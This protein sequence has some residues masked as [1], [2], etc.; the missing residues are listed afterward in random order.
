MPILYWCNNEEDSNYDDKNDDDH[1][2]DDNEDDADDDNDCTPTELLT[3]GQTASLEENQG[4]HDDL[5]YGK[6]YLQSI[7]ENHSL[8]KSH[9]STAPGL[10]VRLA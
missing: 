3:N 1:G 4:V 2:D 7:T 8:C 5:F 9:I 10:Q 6:C